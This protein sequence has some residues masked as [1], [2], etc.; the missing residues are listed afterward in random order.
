MLTCLKYNCK[1]GCVK[2]EDLIKLNKKLKVHKTKKFNLQFAF[3]ANSLSN[4][5]RQS[6]DC[7]ISRFG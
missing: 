4:Y 5:K 6:R 7:Q 3:Q 1:V 2:S